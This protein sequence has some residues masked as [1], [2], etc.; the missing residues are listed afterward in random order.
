MKRV[1]NLMTGV[2]VAALV[3]VVYVLVLTRGSVLR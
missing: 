2:L 1:L 3:L